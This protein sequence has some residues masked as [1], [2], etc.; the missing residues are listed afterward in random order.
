MD[1]GALTFLL[2][3]WGFILSLVVWSLTKLLKSNKRKG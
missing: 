3:S 1:L 2:I